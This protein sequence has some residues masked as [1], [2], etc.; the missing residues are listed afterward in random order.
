M[1]L[2]EWFEIVGKCV[3]ISILPDS[4]LDFYISLKSS[5]PKEIKEKLVRKSWEFSQ[6]KVRFTYLKK[7][8]TCESIYKNWFLSYW[9]LISFF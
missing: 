4:N 9:I 7:K 2:I 8:E 6:R 1:F 5:S 3:S